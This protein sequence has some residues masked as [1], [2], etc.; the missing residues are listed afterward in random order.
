MVEYLGYKFYLQSTGRYYSVR[1]L[2]LGERLLHR[3]IWS[4][5][6][7]KIP[8]GYCVHHKNHDWADNRISNLELI[9]NSEH[10]RYHSKKRLQDPRINEKNNL[11]LDK[12]RPKSVAWHRSVE[13]RNWHVVHAK[14]IFQYKL[15]GDRACYDCGKIYK[16]RSVK[17]LCCSTC[18][19]RRWRKENFDSLQASQQ[20]Y[21]LK[22]KLQIL[23]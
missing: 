14:K 20:K 19:H 3:V 17:I 4:K 15:V 8:D 11:L 7:G 1:V 10:S 12:I 9:K 18:Y 13:G 22:K 6:N 21:R 2:V 5:Y 16:T 23:R